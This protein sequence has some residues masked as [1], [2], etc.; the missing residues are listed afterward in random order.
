MAPMPPKNGPRYNEFI[1]SP[2][3]R[4]IDE[5]G[6]ILGHDAPDGHL[7]RDRVDLAPVQALL[8]DEPLPILG[9]DPRSATGRKVFNA[10]PLWVQGRQAG[11]IYVVLVGEQREAL[12]AMLHRTEKA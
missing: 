10:A 3:V 5:E 8:H 2:K 1:A 6:R 4:V 7:K 9:D 11:Y 12:A